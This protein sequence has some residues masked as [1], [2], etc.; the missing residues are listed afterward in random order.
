MIILAT[1]ENLEDV[2][3]IKS[4]FKG[5]FPIEPCPNPYP[6]KIFEHEK[7]ILDRPEAFMTA[8]KAVKLIKKLIEEN[9]R[10]VVIIT[11]MP[12]IF[13][14]VDA[15]VTIKPEMKNSFSILNSNGKIEEAVR[16]NLE[17]LTE[18]YYNLFCG[19]FD[20]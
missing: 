3:K 6:E 14:F 16:E 9:K 15:I 8:Q 1:W 10:E 5:Y 2:E 19:K 18:V 20:D 17:K 7:V 13:K 11:N 4:S 12:E